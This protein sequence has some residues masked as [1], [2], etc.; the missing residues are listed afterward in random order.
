MVA[1]DCEHAR[2]DTQGA[3]R[4]RTSSRSR[5]R[6]GVRC[7]RIRPAGGAGATPPRRFSTARARVAV[8]TANATRS[9]AAER[10]M[11]NPRSIAY[12]E[13]IDVC[14]VAIL[15][16][17]C[18]DGGNV[19]PILATRLKPGNRGD[20]HGSRRCAPVSTVLA[21]EIRSAVFSRTTIDSRS[22]SLNPEA[23]CSGSTSRPPAVRAGSR[24]CRQRVNA[25]LAG[26][27]VHV[28]SDAA[29][30]THRTSRVAARAGTSLQ[31][32]TPLLTR[33]PQLSH[34]F[35]DFSSFDS[36]SSLISLSPI[37]VTP[38]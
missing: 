25:R 32:T 19:F 10:F 18:S 3:R 13:Y 1:G 27:E 16:R 12:F 23:D 11:H 24:P 8:N 33:L 2:P 20:R 35:D 28:R 21:S 36:R 6:E 34:D 26:T 31:H 4:K 29:L 9:A 5:S 22:A 30:C 37:F 14:C 7:R 38:L 17:T 15:A